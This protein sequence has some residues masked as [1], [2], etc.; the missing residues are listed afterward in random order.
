[1]AFGART[2]TR[3]P[4]PRLIARRKALLAE[5]A[6]LETRRRAGSP[7]DDMRRQRLLAELEQVYGE[8][9]EAHPPRGGGEDVAA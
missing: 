2:T 9:D 3:D 1:M 6:A 5:L 4:R 8:L 7:V